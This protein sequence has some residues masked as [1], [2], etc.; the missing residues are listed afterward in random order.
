M[1]LEAFEERVRLRNQ[2]NAFKQLER[3][4]M[5]VSVALVLSLLD[6]LDEAV[7]SGPSES[8]FRKKYGMVSHNHKPI[9]EDFNAELNPCQFDYGNKDEKELEDDE[10]AALIKAN[11]EHSEKYKGKAGFVAVESFNAGYRFAM[12]KK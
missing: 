9:T 3:P 7:S 8:E 10:F 12:G 4:T 5:G 2:A 6:Q 1:K 11:M